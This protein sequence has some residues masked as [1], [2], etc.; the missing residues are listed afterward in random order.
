MLRGIAGTP[1]C[2]QVLSYTSANMVR[3]LAAPGGY[4]VRM[5]LPGGVVGSSL[6]GTP[7]NWPAVNKGKHNNIL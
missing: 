6:V 2:V 7:Q 5:K 1:I 3:L 4:K